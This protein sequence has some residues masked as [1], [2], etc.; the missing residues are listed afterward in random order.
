VD[1]S[2]VLPPPLTPEDCNLQDFAFMPL[3]V[4]RLRDSGLAAEGTPEENWAAVLLWAASWHQVPAGSMP[5][6]DTWLAK[7]AGYLMRGQIDPRWAEVRAG[8]MRGFVQCSDGRHYHPVICAK[9]AEAWAAKLDQRWRTEC[10]RIK[11]HSDRHHLNLPRPSFNEWLAQGRPQG[12]R[13]PVP[14]D[15]GCPAGQGGGVPGDSGPCPSDVPGETLSKRERQ[16]QEQ[17][18]G[19]ISSVANAT[20]ADAPPA[21]R[22]AKPA[23]AGKPR[24]EEDPVKREI[25]DTGLRLRLV[26]D[27]ARD[28][29]AGF[30]AKLIRDFGQPAVLE[31]VR[32]AETERPFNVQEYLM[33]G[34]LR[35]TGRRLAP[36]AT[37]QAAR[38]ASINAELD[39]MIFQLQNPGVSDDQIPPASDAIDVPSRVVG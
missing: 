27:V 35:A 24:R 11:K 31:V 9:A 8:A 32:A 39:D 6:S 12:Q 15:N 23:K 18:Q 36:V 26:G 16:G 28:T 3:D 37:G 14:G 34:C 2:E 7:H 30:L 21:G 25:W 22:T 19:Q 29:V 13:L 10:G 33:A 1:P 5:N 20:G 38:S 4:Q 17:G